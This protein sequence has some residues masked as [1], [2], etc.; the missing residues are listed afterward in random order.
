MKSKQTA[1]LL[2]LFLGALGAHQ[3]YLGN[4]R[5]WLYLVFSI[6]TIPFFVSIFDLIRLATMNKDKFNDRY[7]SDFKKMIQEAIGGEEK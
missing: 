6:T 5:A 1:I 3:F 4:K 7:N 2:C